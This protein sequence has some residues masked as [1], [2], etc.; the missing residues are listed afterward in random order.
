MYH[1]LS[2][3]NT[4]REWEQ[5]KPC[6]RTNNHPPRISK[7][8]RLIRPSYD[9]V[10]IGSGYGGAIAAS[11]MARAGQSVCLLE[12]GR[13]RWPG[14]YPETLSH[15]ARQLS[16]SGRIQRAFSSRRGG[17]IRCGNAGGMYHVVVGEGQ[18]AVV[19][20]GLGGTSLINSNV[21]L[22]ADAATLSLDMWPPEIRNNP[23]VLD[24][25]YQ[26][27]RNVLEPQPYPATLPSLKKT[28]LLH[29]Q[30]QTLGLEKH[31]YKPPQT[32][33]FQHAGPNSCGVPM[34]PSTLTG[35]DTTGVNDGSK[36]TTLVTYLAD[37]WHWGADIFCQCEVRHVQEAHGRG[38]YNVHYTWRDE[39]WDGFGR[40]TKA[41]PGTLLHVHARRAVFFGAGSLGTTE[42]L[43][44][45]RALGL[46]VS[47][48]VGRGMS[49]NGDMLAFGYNCDYDVNAI[50]R[51]ARRRGSRIADTDPV[52]PTITATI[53]MRDATD[54]PLHGFVIQEGTVPE[55]LAHLVQPIAHLQT[56]LC[57]SGQGTSGLVRRMRRLGRV[58]RS[59]L[60]GPH[61]RSGAVRRTQVFLVM[62][63][64]TA[65]GTMR[66]E[67]DMPTLRF[68]P[69]TADEGL[70]EQAVHALLSAA[71]ASVGG[72]LIRNPCAKLWGNRRVTVHPL[73]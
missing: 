41:T 24:E 33:R 7:P 43:L 11:R 49:G 72:T 55:A 37:A 28:E 27:A 17:N 71:V 35:Q 48:D 15:A 44:R 66:L 56:G 67:H 29:R 16:V 40:G 5:E 4:S 45:S 14:E 13:E 9:C 61:V 54:D 58:C 57:P 26:K 60:L 20:N 6:P 42:I 36:T 23:K 12:R 39:A 8:P 59:R 2:S 19:G 31:F 32:T 25:Y 34:R 30:A 50:G 38:G 3:N 18:T 70:R 1:R 68:P 21:F 64:D 52:G 10:V 62:S 22:E 63:H 65:Q 53:D 46:P 47:D 69:A 51:S 73:G